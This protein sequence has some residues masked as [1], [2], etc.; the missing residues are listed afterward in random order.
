VEEISGITLSGGEPTE[1]PAGLMELLHAIQQWRTSQAEEIDVLMYTGRSLEDAVTELP[2]IPDLVDVVIS[3]PFDIT[4]TT[5]AALKGSDNQV[6]T[7]FTPLAQDRYAEDQREAAY[8][9]Q[10]T[11]LDVLVEEQSI[12]MAGIPLPGDLDRMAAA[13]ARKGLRLQGSTWKEKTHE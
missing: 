7:L 2:E 5:H 12:W 9:W 4:R 3:E 6:I 8:R 11:H 10:R 1:Q 13:A